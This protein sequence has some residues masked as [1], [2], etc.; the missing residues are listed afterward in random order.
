MDGGLI[1]GLLI[2]IALL[3]YAITTW[4][5]TRKDRKD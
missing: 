3:G 5:D 2:V 4:L 1:F